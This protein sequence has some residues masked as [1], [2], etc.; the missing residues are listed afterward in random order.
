MKNNEFE[1]LCNKY[2][3]LL[4]KFNSIH[5]LTTYKN[6]ELDSQ[7]QDS[8]APIDIFPDILNSKTAIDIGSGAGFPALF[9]AAKMPEC[10]W[11]LFEPISKK[12]SFLRYCV[13]E[14]GL[15]NVKIY[16][17]KIENCTKFKADLITSRALSKTSN[18]IKLANGF[19]DKN[20]KFLLY[21]GSSANDEVIEIKAN[22][23]LK[24]IKNK[25]SY[26]LMDKI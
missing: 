12:S 16:S 2:K 20:T 9:L 1:I 7:I 17:N 19:Y 3:E 11:N 22:I 26:I 23:M 18:I 24:R 14:L 13:V 10:K 6:D 4:K 8:I 21:K 5:S 25:R 15:Q